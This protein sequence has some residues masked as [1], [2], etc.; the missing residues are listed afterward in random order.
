MSAVRSPY[1]LRPTLEIVAERDSA[2]LGDWPRAN[3]GAHDAARI[4]DLA[5]HSR[6]HVGV[7]SLVLVFAL[8]WFPYEPDDRPRR[9]FTVWRGSSQQTAAPGRQG[10]L[11]ERRQVWGV[12]P[13]RAL[14]RRPQR[15]NLAARDAVADDDQPRARLAVR[16]GREAARGMKDVLR[17][18]D[19]QRPAG[20]VGEADQALDA[21]QPR[22]EQIAQQVEKI[23]PAPAAAAKVSLSKT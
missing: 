8:A 2:V 21:Q 4:S 15:G 1:S 17:A 3:Q 19:Q 14:Q 22:P 5:L 23:A 12:D 10:V 9:P 11:G 7:R 6:Q 20:I 13:R 18:V 16:P